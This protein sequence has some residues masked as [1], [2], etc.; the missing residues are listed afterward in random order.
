MELEAETPAAIQRGGAR[1]FFARVRDA[2]D[3]VEGNYDVVVIDCPPP[4]SAS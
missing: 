2:L 1:A 4:N 3:S